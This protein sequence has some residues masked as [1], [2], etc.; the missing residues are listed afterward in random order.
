MICMLHIPNTDTQTQTQLLLL[1]QALRQ[2]EGDHPPPPPP[3]CWA[4]AVLRMGPRLGKRAY[5][6]HSK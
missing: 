2:G 3:C 1:L 5:A 6:S 4:V